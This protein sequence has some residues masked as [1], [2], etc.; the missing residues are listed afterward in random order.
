MIA[1][2]IR[3]EGYEMIGLLFW[4]AGLAIAYYLPTWV[5]V[6]FCI[7]GGLICDHFMRRDARANKMVHRHD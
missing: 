1:R 3:P 7:T 6:F 4:I 5:V 2:N